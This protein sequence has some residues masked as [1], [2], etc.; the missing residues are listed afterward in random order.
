MAAPACSDEEFIEL[1][2][3]HGT[4]EK[5]AVVMGTDVRNVYR[6][7]R[8][9][10]QRHKMPLAS[11]GR[12]GEHYAHLSTREHKAR[13]EMEV[14]NGVVIV[15]SDAHFWPGVRTT[16]FRGLLKMIGDLQPVAV[17]NNGDAFDGASV[18]RHARIMWQS[19]PS[20]IDELKACTQR[21]CEVEDASGKAKL[22]WP[23]GNHDARFET[24][25]SQNA[26]EY[27][28]VK[29]FH[30]KDH[31][32]RWKP[33]WS[34]WINGD[35]VVKH[36]WHNGVHA[37]RNNIAKGGKSM[38]TGHLHSLKVTPLS[39]YNGTRFGVD[40]GTLA[41]PSG[42]QF[43]DYLECNPTDWRSGF[44]VLTFW[45]GRLLW[46]EV[47]NVIGQNEIEFRGQVMKV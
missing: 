46:P 16:A 13:H 1:W 42:P 9:L 24:R 2:K 27:Q 15:F 31:F 12:Q 26:P 25:L 8:R 10:E 14:Q 36:R 40:T 33:C 43:E 7:R 18:S 5:V 45:K 11:E 47:V 34:A 21:L 29:G 4:A 17:I 3:T 19:T 35:V 41:D 32:P 30:L 22:I 20:V 37:V 28:G 6:R 44:A 23:L 38:V 39:D